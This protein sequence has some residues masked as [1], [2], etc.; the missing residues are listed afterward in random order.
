MDPDDDPGGEVPL[1]EVK[2]W[3]YI[4]VILAIISV[5]LCISKASGSARVQSD[6][7]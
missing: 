7:S 5:S 3:R 4:H 2:Y 6:D 1:A